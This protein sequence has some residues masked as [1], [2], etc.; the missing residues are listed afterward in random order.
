MTKK[1]YYMIKASR[2]KKDGD[3]TKAIRW[4]QKAM[5]ASMKECREC[6][7]FGRVMNCL[8]IFG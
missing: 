3:K 8:I 4:Y 5:H 7:L 1:G 2:A 6:T